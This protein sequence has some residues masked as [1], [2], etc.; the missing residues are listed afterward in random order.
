V[1]NLWRWYV[2]HGDAE[3]Q[4]RLEDVTRDLLV[5]LDAECPLEDDLTDA[6]NFFPACLMRAHTILSVLPPE[7]VDGWLLRVLPADYPIAPVTSI[8]SAHVS[9][10]NF[11]R[12]WGLWSLYEATGDTQFRDA[13]RAHV[14][15]QLDHPE[16]WAA[17]YDAYSHWVPQ[18]GVYVYAGME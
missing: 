18:F 14:E 17:N 5:P 12:N 1:L 11:S 3:G 10:L 2:S 9:G 4:A 7:E 13:V 8:T 15:W 6:D 16:Y